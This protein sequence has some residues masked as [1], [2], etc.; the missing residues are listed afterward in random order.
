MVVYLYTA[1]RIE[2]AQPIILQVSLPSRPQQPICVVQGEAAL[3][4]V[5]QAVMAHLAEDAADMDGGEAGSVGHMQLPQR[6]GIDGTAEAARLQP[7]HEA[8]Q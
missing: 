4:L 3:G 1:A 2:V 7:L 8:G 5:Q 6:Q